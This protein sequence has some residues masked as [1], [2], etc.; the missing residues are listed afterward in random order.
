MVN[1]EVTKIESNK[2]LDNPTIDFFLK[3]EDGDAHEVILMVIQKPD[4]S[5]KA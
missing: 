5:G 1:L 2:N 4:N 3:D